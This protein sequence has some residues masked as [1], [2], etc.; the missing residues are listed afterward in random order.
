MDARRE[1]TEGEWAILEVVWD[2]QPCA[3]GDVQE[4][5][6]KTT[7]WTYSTVKT[8]MDR[9]VAKEL[10]ATE[11]VRNLVLYRPAITRPQAQ[12][13]ELMRTVQRAFNGAFS[14]LVEFLLDQDKLSK[15]ELEHLERL[16]RQKQDNT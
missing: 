14:P 5:L 13:G 7:G 3:A 1:L 2:R 16:I 15:E 8:M 11:R 4:A 9:M 12:S 10:L 6:E